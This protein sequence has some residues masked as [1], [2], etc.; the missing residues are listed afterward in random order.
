MLFVN[1]LSYV[2]LILR[3]GIIEFKLRAKWLWVIL[4]RGI[5]RYEPTYNFQKIYVEEPQH[6]NIIFN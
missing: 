5:H 2:D 3:S 1:F 4:E 6:P